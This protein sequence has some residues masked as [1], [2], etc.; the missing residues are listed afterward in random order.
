MI[1]RA[2]IVILINCSEAQCGEYY[3]TLDRGAA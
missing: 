2:K 1:A 3:G